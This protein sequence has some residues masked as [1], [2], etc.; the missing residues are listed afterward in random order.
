MGLE[1]QYCPTC[2][3]VFI[4]KQPLEKCPTCERTDLRDAII[5]GEIYNEVLECP[6]CGSREV[7]DVYTG[8]LV[9]YPQQR[10]VS[11]GASALS[12]YCA[13]CTKTGESSGDSF[14][15]EET[16]LVDIT[17][18]EF[19]RELLGL[20][21][22]ALRPGT[23]T[24]LY[25]HLYDQLVDINDI[26]LIESTNSTEEVALDNFDSFTITRKNGDRVP[27][28][29]KSK[30]EIRKNLLI[31]DTKENRIL[32]LGKLVPPEALV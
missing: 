31:V 8:E 13:E 4:S 26:F 5:E 20:P 11:A 30:E 32:Y 17:W 29:F 27:V 14:D 19:L 3:V 2:D 22:E 16:K 9:I 12:W 24:L 28:L 7:F 1:F 23:R 6:Y 25:F 18:E 15:V 21:E 10:R